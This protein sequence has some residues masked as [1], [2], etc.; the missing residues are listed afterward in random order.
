MWQSFDL[1]DSVLHKLTAG[2]S[3]WPSE[4]WFV[5]VLSAAS[6]SILFWGFKLLKVNIMNSLWPWDDLVQTLTG[7]RE[8]AWNSDGTEKDMA[9]AA[10]GGA[11]MCFYGFISKSEQEIKQLL[12]WQSQQSFCCG[13]NHSRVS[14]PPRWSL[15][16]AV[17]TTYQNQWI[18]SPDWLGAAW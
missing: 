15:I 3:S 10:A 9:A 16:Q 12:V 13:T 8:N 5:L 17:S 14:G 6:Y 18:T 7:T 11:S 2:F 4:S 1:G